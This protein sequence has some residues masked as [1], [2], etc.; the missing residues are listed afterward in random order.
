MKEEY[1]FSNAVIR[2][3]RVMKEIVI[4]QEIEF[5][6]ATFSWLAEEARKRGESYSEFL[7]EVLSMVMRDQKLQEES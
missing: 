1:D 5:Q 3:K 4:I 6:H 7:E 2:K